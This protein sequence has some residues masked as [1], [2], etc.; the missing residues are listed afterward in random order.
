MNYLNKPR[1]IKTMKLNFRNLLI[2]FIICLFGM[3]LLTAQRAAINNTF[4][5]DSLLID[6]ARYVQNVPLNDSIS[7]LKF[8][9]GDSLRVRNMEYFGHEYYNLYRYYDLYSFNMNFSLIQWSDSIL[10]TFNFDNSAFNERTNSSGIVLYKYNI[11]KGEFYRLTSVGF[12]TFKRWNHE[13]NG[14]FYSLELINDNTLLVSYGEERFGR[15]RYRIVR[16]KEDK[17]QIYNLMSTS[18]DAFFLLNPSFNRNS[19]NP[20]K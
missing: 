16:F 19:I 12:T 3:Q 9:N 17:V 15:I 4:T 8:K 6:S 14:I 10:F 13:G 18:P 11:E 1:V 7:V 20:K 2:S 5:F